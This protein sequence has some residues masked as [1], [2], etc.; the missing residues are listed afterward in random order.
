MPNYKIVATITKITSDGNVAING[1]G[2]HR[3]EK[4]RDEVYNLLE[5]KNNP[6]SSKLLKQDEHYSVV[7]PN[8]IITTL[9]SMAMLNK[10]PLKLTIEEKEDKSEQNGTATNKEYKYSI[11][12]VEVP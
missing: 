6:L 2:K 10:K 3:Y 12:E 5:E 1:V 11:Q 7:N 9:L 8:S 4:S